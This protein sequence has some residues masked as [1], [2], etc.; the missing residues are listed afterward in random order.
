M[1]SRNLPMTSAS[2]LLSLLAHAERERNAAMSEAKRVELVH[3]NA[4]RQADQLL[5]YRN[6]YE[7][8]WGQR[9]ADGGGIDIVQCYQGFMA[10]LGDAIGAQQRVVAMAAQRLEDAQLLW[11]QREIRVA[12]IRKLMDRRNVEV[13][14]VEA[15]RE[16][17]QLDEQAV[18]SA[19]QR[20]AGVAVTAT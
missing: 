20:A 2:A 16:Q 17:K 10:R 11:Q 19:W 14:A 8:R 3:R 1:P 7:Q 18:R 12:S 5:A 4:Q 9:F 6:D 15:R 13:Q